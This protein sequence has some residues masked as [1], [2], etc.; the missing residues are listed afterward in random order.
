MWTSKT[1][2]SKTKASNTSPTKGPAKRIGADMVPWAKM[3]TVPIMTQSPIRQ[4]LA[5]NMSP[6]QDSNPRPTKGPANR[7]G[8]DMVPW[9]KMA[10]VTTMSQ[11]GISYAVASNW[12]SKEQKASSTRMASQAVPHP[13][14]DR[15]LQRLTSE[16][17]RD[18][19]YS[20]WYGR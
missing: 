7:I 19:V 9:A 1:N 10:T 3:A 14:T 2:P 20:L 5:S 15:A 6:T 17:E 12:L 11:R 13:S 18:L 4:A 8:A 16:F